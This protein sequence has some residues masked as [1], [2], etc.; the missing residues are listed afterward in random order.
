MYKDYYIEGIYDYY[1]SFKPTDKTKNI[2][3]EPKLY[4]YSTEIRNIEGYGQSITLSEE[5]KGSS[6]LTTPSKKMDLM[7]VQMEICSKD[8]GAAFEFRNAFYNT[9]LHESGEIPANFPYFFRNIKNTNLDT[10]LIFSGTKSTKIF[11][12]HVGISQAYSPSIVQLAIEYDPQTY[13]L[14]FN[15]PIEDEYFK[16]TILLDKKGNLEKQDYSLCSFAE[17]SKLAHYSTSINSNEKNN[18]LTLD[19]T[20]DILKGYE[21]SFDVLILAEQINKGKLVFLSKVLQYEKKEKGDGEGS[22]GE[23]EGE[24]GDGSNTAL[25]IIICVLVIIILSGGLFIFFYLRKTKKKVNETKT[26]YGQTTNLSDIDKAN[27]GDKLINSM[28]ESQASE[29]VN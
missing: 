11:V 14:S 17:N 26:F 13:T 10:E 20:T 2:T 23:G 15:Q 3:I 9:S 4:K 12:K 7:I 24:G 8:V 19:F 25:I 5:G 18:K 27:Q 21:D 6:I 28:A 1:V 29:K 16:Y 22:D